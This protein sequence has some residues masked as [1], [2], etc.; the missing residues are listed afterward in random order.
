MLTMKIPEKEK[1]TLVWLAKNGPNIGLKIAKGANILKNTI[2]VCLDK[3]QNKG[4]IVS[5]ALKR[6][7][8][9]KKN[10]KG[11]REYSLTFR[12]LIVA[13]SYLRADD[14]DIISIREHWGHL[15]PR[16]FDKWD[17]FKEHNVEDQAR[18]RLIL[19]SIWMTRPVMFP[20][21]L[22]E[23]DSEWEDAIKDASK[24]EDES[25]F[26]STFYM[27]DAEY[28]QNDDIL[29]NLRNDNMAA[30][31]WEIACT[32]DSELYPYFV[33]EYN[34]SIRET[35]KRLEY[36]QYGLDMIKRERK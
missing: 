20:Q 15:L 2:Y 36:Q 19:T 21:P 25:Y 32:N 23:F 14:I 34:K 13:L 5:R 27:S 28:L 22:V 24:N 29:I 11:Q 10:T 31:E 18:N 7:N 17:H 16:V 26:T 35:K 6:D 33:E 12:G 9:R 3:L 4:L 1:N 8:K 30:Y